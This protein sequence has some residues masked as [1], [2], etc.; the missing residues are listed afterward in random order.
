[1]LALLRDS[2]FFTW[3]DSRRVNDLEVCR[4]PGCSAIF[5]VREEQ[6]QGE[7][8]LF[9][10]CPRG[11]VNLNGSSSPHERHA[12]V[13]RDRCVRPSLGCSL[14]RQRPVLPIEPGARVGVETREW[15]CSCGMP[16]GWVDCWCSRMPCSYPYRRAMPRRATL[17]PPSARIPHS[18]LLVPRPVS[19]SPVG[20]I[21]LPA[22]TRS[23]HSTSNIVRPS[24]SFCTHK[25][26]ASTCLQLAC[27]CDG[28]AAP[29]LPRCIQ[30]AGASHTA[31][32][33]DVAATP[34]RRDQGLLAQAH[35][36]PWHIQIPRSPPAA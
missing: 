10:V 5:T 18:A 13:P 11:I 3:V 7:R 27:P 4:C 28:I 1:M 8:V 36:P 6:R 21:R 26:A 32:A 20:V 17:Q 25:H 33:A 34:H 31:T 14:G 35:I 9:Y 23:R 22:C 19:C 29:I 16:C 15:W 30:R 2:G 24:Y 12:V